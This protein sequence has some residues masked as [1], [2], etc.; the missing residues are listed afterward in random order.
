VALAVAGLKKLGFRDAE[1]RDLVT[2]AM[3]DTAP[4]R[5]VADEIVGAALRISVQKQPMGAA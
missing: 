4:E 1:A 2:R 3:T 5:W